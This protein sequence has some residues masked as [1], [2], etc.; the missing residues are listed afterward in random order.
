M[1]KHIEME[2]PRSCDTLNEVNRSSCLSLQLGA[3]YPYHPY[4]QN[5]D[6]LG[7]KKFKDEM[8]MNIQGSSMD[9]RV[10]NFGTPSYD[11]NMSNWAST[12]DNCAVSL[13]DEN[14]FQSSSNASMSQSF[15]QGSPKS[16]LAYPRGGEFD[17]ESGISKKS[18]R[19]KNS[20]PELF[21]MIKSIGHRLHYHY[22]LHPLFVFLVSL[23]TGLGIIIV[24]AVYENRF[25]GMGFQNKFEL[26]STMYP[27]P[28]LR[29]LVMVAGHSV[30]TSTSCEKV[31]GEN[32]WFLESYQK[33]PGQAA[34]FLQHI[35]EGVE[36]AAKDKNALL[37]FSGGE[38]RKDAGPRSEA[39]SYWSVAD[40]KGWFGESTPS[41]VPSYSHPYLSCPF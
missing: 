28:D 30:Y 8:E 33:H 25:R 23:A 39:Q 40:S 37:L 38:T 17:L 13:F 2:Q 34:T 18:R 32:S 4:N 9:Y 12:S 26:D 3:F 15:G 11:N 24:L 19:P 14:S 6:F 5:H 29:N 1:G 7:E 36:I 16:F 20:R 27:Y 35:R 21:K 31:D 22:K 41:S 10:P